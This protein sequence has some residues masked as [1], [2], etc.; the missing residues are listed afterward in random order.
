[1]ILLFD[2]FAVARIPLPSS[3]PPTIYFVLSQDPLV[4]LVMVVWDSEMVHVL[5][6]FPDGAT[7]VDALSE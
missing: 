1:M 5:K 7:S 2:S 3:F 4:L 6:I